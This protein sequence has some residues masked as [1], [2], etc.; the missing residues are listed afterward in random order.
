MPGHSGSCISRPIPP[1]FASFDICAV[2]R[3]EVHSWFL[4]SEGVGAGAQ[5]ER[6]T[7][8]RCNHCTT[9]VPDHSSRWR[10]ELFAPTPA[11]YSSQARFT[12]GAPVSDHSVPTPA[13]LVFR[14]GEL[15]RRTGRMCVRLLPQI[16]H[17]LTRRVVWI[18]VA[19]CHAERFTYYI[20]PVSFALHA[21]VAMSVFY[22]ATHDCPIVLTVRSDLT[23]TV[24]G[25]QSA[26]EVRKRTVCTW[27]ACDK[28]HLIIAMPPNTRV[29]SP[30]KV[31]VRGGRHLT[32]QHTKASL[33]VRWPST[34]LQAMASIAVQCVA[35]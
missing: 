13:V 5:D 23:L 30:I 8:T 1:V 19:G 7:Y 11:V 29:P 9:K 12:D 20:C 18:L 2:A 6:T 33:G 31:Q 22:R 14:F 10:L 16:P 25:L 15:S 17:T 34:H 28:Q 26:K 24:H 4:A 32:P 21:T 3:L 35:R 27:V